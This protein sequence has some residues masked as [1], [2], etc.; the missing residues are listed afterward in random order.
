MNYPN[1]EPEVLEAVHLMYED[2]P[3]VE[4]DC[5]M[6]LKSLKDDDIKTRN[7]SFKVEN[8]LEKMNRCPV[9]GEV[10]QVHHYKEPHTEVDGC[11]YENMTETYCPNCDMAGQTRLF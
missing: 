9:C 6:Y 7:L 5:L 10:M 3:E 11:P 8:V 4:V 2:D 1:M